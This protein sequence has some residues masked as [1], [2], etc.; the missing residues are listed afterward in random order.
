MWYDRLPL[1]SRRGCGLGV[2][3]C[4]VMDGEWS[5]FVTDCVMLN[6]KVLRV[7]TVTLTLL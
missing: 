1:G 5:L 2:I 3:L 7:M 6:I 4:W